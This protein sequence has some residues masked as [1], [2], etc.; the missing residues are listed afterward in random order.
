MG[1]KYSN[2]L[3]LHYYAK[4]STYIWCVMMHVFLKCIGYT[5][6]YMFRDYFLLTAV[7]EPWSSAEVE[8]LKIFF[9]KEIAFRTVPNKEECEKFKLKSGNKRT[10]T[11]IKSYVKNLGCKATN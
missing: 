9:A 7:R 11:K 5:F 8:E 6:T 3:D 10:W 2:T 1:S 4:Y